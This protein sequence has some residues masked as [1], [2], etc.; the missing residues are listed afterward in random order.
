MIEDKVTI[1]IPAHNSLTTIKKTL[2]SIC[3]LNRNLI[4]EIIYIDD[5]SDDGSR[6]FVEK[7]YKK[8]NLPLR[9]IHNKKAQG[10]AKNFNFGIKNSKTRFLLTMHQDMEV[11]DSM[12][13]EK[14]MEILKNDSKGV[15]LYSKILHP[16]SLLKKYNFWMKVNFSRVI[17]RPMNFSA[18][19]FDLIDL[20]KT[21]IL[22]NETI[23][24]H[25]GEDAGFNIDVRRKGF[26]ILNSDVEVIHNHSFDPNYSFIKYLKKE[27]QLNE[28]YG[29]LIRN[30]GFSA[31]GLKGSILMLH[32]LLLVTS[33]LIP[34]LN[35]CILFLIIFYC[36]YYSKRIFSRKIYSLEKN[37]PRILTVPFAN[38]IVLFSGAIWNIIGYIKG[39]QSL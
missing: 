12:A 13:L 35:L 24:T 16:F 8:I 25:S 27:N 17:E 36:F 6:E 39:K 22:F 29:V 32:R 37:N 23:F 15:L 11:I 4:E 10:L 9:I 28:T 1:L 34:F 19:K 7:Y 31:F 21:K 20:K 2:D 33:L 5:N 14:S 18:G 26:K 3:I 30:Y 38:F